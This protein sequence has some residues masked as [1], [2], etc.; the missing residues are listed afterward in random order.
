[1]NKYFSL[2]SSYKVDINKFD[3]LLITGFGNFSYNIA[4]Y[5]E[6][7]VIFQQR[8][9]LNLGLGCRSIGEIM[10][11][12]MLSFHKLFPKIKED[13]SLAYAF[14]YGFKPLQNINS[15]SHEI[16]LVYKF[17]TRPNPEQILKN[18]TAVHP[19]FF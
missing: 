17:A 1:M 5:L 18:K 4:P 12:S 3:K 10:F 16:L 7:N 2:L 8:M 19:I 14:D 6:S 11:I 13:M 15:N 9:G